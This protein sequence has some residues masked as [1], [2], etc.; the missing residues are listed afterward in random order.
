MLESQ[1]SKQVYSVTGRFS[2]PSCTLMIEADSEV[3]AIDR[4]LM[5]LFEHDHICFDEI[6][7]VDDTK[8]GTE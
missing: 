5:A 4:F 3:D 8:L 6:K 7:V 2:S 1:M